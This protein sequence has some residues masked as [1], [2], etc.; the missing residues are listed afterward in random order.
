MRYVLYLFASK[1]QGLMKLNCCSIFR[2]SQEAS[3]TTATFLPLPSRSLSRKMTNM[4][5]AG[6]GIGMEAVVSS[7]VLKCRA[8]EMTAAGRMNGDT[9]DRGRERESEREIVERDMVR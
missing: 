3:R 7:R 6:I 5:E 8:D 4:K 2:Q 1:S 9:D